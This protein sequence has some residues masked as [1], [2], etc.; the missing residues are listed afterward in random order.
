ME[1]IIDEKRYRNFMILFYKTSNFY[2]YD[3]IIFNIHSFK[4]YAYIKHN[5]EEE[6]KEEHY[7]AFIHLDTACTISSLSKRIGI[8]Q[9]YI[10]SV[11]NVRGSCRYLTHIDYEEKTQYSIDD[12]VVSGIFKRK[13]LKCFEDVKTEEQIID[14]IYSFISNLRFD[15]YYERVRNLILFVNSNCYDTVYKRYRGEFLDYLKGNM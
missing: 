15:T 9:N 12:V 7:H 10:Q 1:E 11:K 5:P 6:E 8:P 14:E 2:S 4:Y 3:D 13:F